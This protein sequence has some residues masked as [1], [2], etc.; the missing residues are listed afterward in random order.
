MTTSTTLL[1]LEVTLCQQEPSEFCL[2][3]F[4]ADGCLLIL[5]SYLLILGDEGG[6]LQI[7]SEVG[8]LETQGKATSLH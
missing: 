1:S 8:P 2:N 3:T 4:S 5:C 6:G 7:S